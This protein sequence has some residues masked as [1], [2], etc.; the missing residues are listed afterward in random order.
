MRG[1]NRIT[2]A[3]FGGQVYGKPPNSGQHRQAFCYTNFLFFSTLLI[4]SFNRCKVI[5]LAFGPG[6]GGRCV[7]VSATAPPPCPFLSWARGGGSRRGTIQSTLGIIKL[8]RTELPRHWTRTRT[9]PFVRLRSH[10]GQLKIAGHLASSDLFRRSQLNRDV[11]A[12]RYPF[13][14]A[15]N[16]QNRPANRCKSGRPSD[17]PEKNG[18]EEPKSGRIGEEARNVPFS[19][20]VLGSRVRHVSPS[21]RVHV[22]A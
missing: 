22:H 18:T 7:S 1:R 14:T 11:N 10:L 13:T 15:Q 20:N 4:I 16:G 2:T 21:P 19:G 5:V 6:P 9:L 3:F 12:L 8:K 17:T